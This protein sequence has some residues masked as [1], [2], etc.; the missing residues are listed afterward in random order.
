MGGRG[1]HGERGAR[2]YNGGLGAVPLVETVESRGKTPGQGSGQLMAFLNLKH[3]F[4]R[5]IL[6]F[7]RL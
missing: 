6:S 7:F 5:K 2:A 4:L 3:N 1:L